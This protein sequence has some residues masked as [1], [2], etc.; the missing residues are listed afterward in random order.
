MS[1][2]RYL[3]INRIVIKVTKYL[4]INYK[5]GTMYNAENFLKN[6]S[7]IKEPQVLVN[8]EFIYS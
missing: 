3:K 4:N 5:S 2:P 7:V 1:H 6:V 8:A